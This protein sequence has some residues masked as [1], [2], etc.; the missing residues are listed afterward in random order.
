MAILTRERTPAIDSPEQIRRAEDDC[1]I[2]RKPIDRGILEH[3]IL[4]ILNAKNMQGASGEMPSLRD[5][6]SVPQNEKLQFIHLFI[7]KTM[8]PHLEKWVDC[9][10]YF[11]FWST[12]LPNGLDVEMAI[13]SCGVRYCLSFRTDADG[14]RSISR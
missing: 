12:T 10:E 2:A 8:K 3:T 1:N 9:F 5:H 4:G 14:A 6:W 7:Q 13:W 11:D